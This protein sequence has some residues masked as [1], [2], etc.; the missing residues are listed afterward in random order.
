MDLEALA[1]QIKRARELDAKNELQEIPSHHP[2][3]KTW[4]YADGDWKYEKTETGL[5]TV[6]G[7]EL[8]FHQNI[9]IW[10]MSWH[11]GMLQNH[12][13]KEISSHITKFLKL[14]LAHPDK[15][16][17]FTGPNFF[18]EDESTIYRDAVRG[19]I[20]SFA[21]SRMIYHYAAVFTQDYVGGLILTQTTS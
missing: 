10:G 13:N 16:N 3:T 20:T 14:A 4:Q 19:D 18:E 1:D 8:I 5:Y 7:Q 11:G 21:G 15:K 12:R 2:L 17:L 9:P 6:Q